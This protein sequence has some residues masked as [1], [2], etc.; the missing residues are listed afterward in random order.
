MGR[1]IDLVIIGQTS[2]DI[3]LIDGRAETA[4]GGGVLYA[5]YAA[6]ATGAEILAVTKLA[7]EDAACFPA[8]ARGGFPF[9]T[10]PPRPP[11]SWRIASKPR[12]ATAVAPGS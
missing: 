6:K 2:K 10:F 4:P 7:A 8:F 3:I 12:A 9:W 11:P 5:S 1:P